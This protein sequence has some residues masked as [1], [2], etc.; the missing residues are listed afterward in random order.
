MT[1]V[2][3]RPATWMFWVAILVFAAHAANY[4]YF[5]VDDEAIPYVYAQ[6]LLH[7]KGLIY[8][9]IEG[10]VEG[11]SD[12]LHVWLAAAILG[13][14]RAV[15][16]PALSVFFFGK[17]LS[18]ACGLA[19]VT[20]AWVVLRRVV[21]NRWAIASGLAVVVLAPPLAVWSCS[22][23]ETV[24][25]ALTVIL[26]AGALMLRLDTQAA[27]AAILVVLERIDGFVY[28][29]ALIGA[30]VAAAHPERRRA[31][32]RRTV[33]PLAIA[34]T[35]YHAWRVFYFRHAL[36][37]PVASKVWYKLRP[38]GELVVK[39]PETS[40]IRRFANLYGW[41]ASIAMGAAAVTGLAAGGT[42]R[43]LSL[44]LVTLTCYVA[45][46][47]DWMFGFR[48]FVPLIPLFGIF[49]ALAI[50]RMAARRPRAAAAVAVLATMYLATVANR[51]LD[52]YRETE[53]AGSFLHG[54]SFDVRR[55]LWPFYDLYEASR[56]LVRP[57]EIIAYNQAGFIPFMLDANNLDDLGICSRFYADL[58]T[59]D[60]YFTEVG[61]YAPLTNSPTLRAGHAY[62][63]Y[64]NARF[65]IA[66]TDILWR[67]NGDEIPAALFGGFYDLVQ[68]DASGENAIYRRSGK[69]AGEYVTDPSAFDENVAH[70]SYVRRATIDGVAVPRTELQRR[71]AFLRDEASD[72]RVPRAV[73]V[74]VDF[75][76]RDEYVRE[77]AVRQMSGTPGAIVTIALVD[78]GGRTVH[79]ASVVL[80]GSVQESRSAVRQRS[81][82]RRLVLQLESPGGDAHVRITDLRVQGQR[83]ALA[84][85]IR[86]RLP[87][88][89]PSS[90]IAR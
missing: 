18:L 4:L 80:S 83:Q 45:V 38:H 61:R 40:Y 69:S 7:G 86:R 47:G 50:D 32:L 78:T 64:E 46:V 9:A 85:F 58:P 22:S 12:F 49:A 60:L 75:A 20:T 84:D 24:P 59:T 53:H 33:L 76:D 30:F 77:V 11:Y 10:R 3:P 56:T 6:N 26:L 88:P 27:I 19:V 68:V 8:N 70:V 79:R 55:Y 41:P 23:L 15:H 82:A 81:A 65:V 5:F 90:D 21:D 62:L 31:V 29:G 74:T 63:L 25:F 17:A 51:F 34:F 14:V 73:T 43:W 89:A 36:P 37:A 44:A 72:F 48:F 42:L 35:A 66:R 1:T 67:A 52:S 71:L 57:G 39:T 28:A 13:V 2:R 54:P 16:L 87:F